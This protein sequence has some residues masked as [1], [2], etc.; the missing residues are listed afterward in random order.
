MI[1]YAISQCLRV[2]YLN[3]NFGCIIGWFDD[4]LS[5]RAKSFLLR[6]GPVLLTV[7]AWAMLNSID[8]S[9]TIWQRRLKLKTATSVKFRRCW[10]KHFE[11][12]SSNAGWLLSTTPH[13]FPPTASD[14]TP[15]S[16][17][18]WHENEQQ[19]QPQSIAKKL[20][21]SRTW[22]AFHT[23]LSHLCACARERWWVFIYKLRQRRERERERERERACLICG[24]WFH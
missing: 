15:E 21:P 3:Y 9:V 8:F 6:Q 13:H 20:F 19:Q 22:A 4:L 11:V 2:Q 18:V 7:D 24:S 1:N 10:R 17:D 12:Q 14:Q 16:C 5:E 23:G